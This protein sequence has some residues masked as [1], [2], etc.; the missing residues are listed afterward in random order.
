MEWKFLNTDRKTAM[1]IIELSQMRE[2]NEIVFYSED[3][4]M[5][6]W[7]VTHYGT[8]WDYV[9]TDIKIDW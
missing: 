9:L 2:T 4:D 7:G 8:S 6:L 1:L 3:L 5:Y